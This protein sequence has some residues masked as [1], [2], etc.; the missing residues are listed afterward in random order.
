[1]AKPATDL[2]AYADPAPPSRLGRVISD[3]ETNLVTAILREFS[4]YQTDR[5][6]FAQQWEE[7]SNLILPTHRNTFYYQSY[8]T[9]GLKKTQQQVDA[10]GALALH[11]FCAIADSLVTPRNMQWHGLSCDDYI[12]KDRNVRLWLEGLTRLLF[13]M[14]YAARANFSAQNYNN[15]QGTGAFG[16][17]TM[18]VDKYDD[19]WNGG[20]RGLRY[21]SLPL[22]QTFYGENHQGQV[23][24]MVRWFRLTPYQAVQKWGREWLP[25]ALVAPLQSDSQWRYNFLHCVRPRA[26]GDYDPDA[27]DHRAMPFQS[28]Y[29][30]IEGRCLMAPESGYRSYP[31]PASRYDQAPDERYGRGPAQI[32]LPALKT[33]NAMK[34]TALK[35]AHRGADPVLLIADDG[36][37]GMDLRPGAQNKGGVT[38][39]GKPLVH[40]LPVGDL[41]IPLEMMQEERGIID[42][43]FLVSLFKVLAE[44]PNMTATQVVALVAEKGMLVAPTLGRQHTEYIGSGLVPREID[45]LFEM[46]M[47]ERPPPRLIEAAGGSR[48]ALLSLIEVTDTS[49]L[50]KAA[51]M[52]EAA[53]FNQWIENL[54]KVASE[55]QDPSWLDGVNADEASRDL[56]DIY[57]VR[58]NWKA[59]PDQIAAKRKARAGAQQQQARIAALPGEAAMANAQAK[60]AASGAQ[61]QGVPA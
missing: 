33:I 59:T 8:N 25:D 17:A 29:V 11:R 32:V 56:A 43:T 14:R 12:K 48:R 13:R 57:S 44:N 39:D 58:E 4:Q 28:Y 40:T 37:V 7:V 54:T 21:K 20:G 60:L 10:S 45:L 3:R 5:S 53:G 31:L 1:M 6:M 27:L 55:M 52:G 46:G 24:R 9:P 61:Q 26:E 50:S 41:K 2:I 23:D 16:N 30:S 51:Q 15:W 35:T 18:Y 49:P 34:T 42:D 22:G 19:R 36:L 47:V 38:A